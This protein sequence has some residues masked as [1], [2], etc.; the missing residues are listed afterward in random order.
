VSGSK[1]TI[2][3]NTGER[4]VWGA[5]QRLADS[6]ENQREVYGMSSDLHLPI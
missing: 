3:E 2:G 6:R 4:Q 1:A 5:C